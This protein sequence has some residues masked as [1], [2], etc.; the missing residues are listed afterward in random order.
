MVD[1]VSHLLTET[2]L[3]GFKHVVNFSHRVS[4]NFAGEGFMVSPKDSFK[5]MTESPVTDVMHKP[6]HTC[7]KGLFFSESTL[8]ETAAHGCDNRINTNRMAKAGMFSAWEGQ[9]R[10]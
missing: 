10:C 9:R 4:E 5:G 6:R 3:I 2:T 1:N 7:E 8:F